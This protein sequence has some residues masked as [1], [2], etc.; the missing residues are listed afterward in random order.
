MNKKYVSQSVKHVIDCL[1]S[2]SKL[3][4]LGSH[5]STQIT[6]CN[7]VITLIQTKHSMKTQKQHMQWA[8][9]VTGYLSN[10]KDV[11]WGMSVAI[12]TLLALHVIYS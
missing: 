12:A 4:H 5:L 2:Y 6:V 3:R 8:H 1:G 11:G 9:V 7:D 10:W